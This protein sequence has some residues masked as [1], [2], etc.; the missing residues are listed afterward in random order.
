[1]NPSPAAH[2]AALTLLAGLAACGPAPLPPSP[3]TDWSLDEPA[4][5]AAPTCLPQPETSS[6]QPPP[7]FTG[8]LPDCQMP[9]LPGDFFPAVTC[10]EHSL[11]LVNIFGTT[12]WHFADPQGSRI[13]HIEFQDALADDEVT[14]ARTWTFDDR[15]RLIHESQVLTRFVGP[16]QITELTHTYEDD[17]L[18]RIEHLNDNAL[19]RTL[20][21]YDEQGRLTR[22]ARTF[23]DNADNAD[24]VASW[25][26]LNGRPTELIRERNN[27]PLVH[28][29]WTFSPEGHLQSMHVDADVTSPAPAA[30]DAYAHHPDWP[31]FIGTPSNNGA[32][33]PRQSSD[34]PCAPLPTSLTYG[35]PEADEVYTLLG[36]AQTL[37]LF[38]VSTAYQGYGLFLRFGLD[39][40]VGHDG[41]GYAWPAAIEPGDH[42][43]TSRHFDASGHMVREELLRFNEGQRIERAERRR[44]HQDGR[45]LSDH[46]DRTLTADA[47]TLPTRTLNFDY[48]AD[49]RLAA[50]TLTSADGTTLQRAS[51]HWENNRLTEHHV[52]SQ[53]DQPHPA[54][55]SYR[56]D[57]TTEAL[58]TGRFTLGDTEHHY[59]LG[60]T[61]PPQEFTQPIQTP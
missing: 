57:D 8:S 60:H 37:E 32:W 54:D 47:R 50:R 45:I 55:A 6:L 59:W 12:T 13:V 26:Y 33:S 42:W 46:L 21:D 34:E 18:I 16:P 49:G 1:M 29:R 22:A 44:E 56:L 4:T 24:E 31:H 38:H 3:D 7:E 25:T 43:Q 23:P 9:A 20:F 52:D 19:T 30:L 35:Y 61:S 36:P 39:H 53:L 11:T 48:H 58:P 27:E 14:V 28:I 51:W 15:E 5:P 17:R 41:A 40:W 10:D 2:I